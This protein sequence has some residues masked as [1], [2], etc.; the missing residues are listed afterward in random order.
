MTNKGDKI[1]MKDGRVGTVVRIQSGDFLGDPSMLH[2]LFTDG[3]TEMISG[4]SI[5]LRG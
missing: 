2:L 3:S 5:K 1:T 4:A